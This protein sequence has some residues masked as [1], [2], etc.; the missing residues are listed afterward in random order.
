MYKT[1]FYFLTPSLGTAQD[2]DKVKTLL[3]DLEADVATLGA[4]RVQVYPS[5][6]WVELYFG[7]T[8]ATSQQM[9]GLLADFANKNQLWDSW[10]LVRAFDG[11][12]KQYYYSFITSS[13]GME[14]GGVPDDV[15]AKL[16]SG[17]GYYTTGRGRPSR[18]APIMTYH[19]GYK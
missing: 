9:R 19:L 16:D 11:L 5:S 12:S 18:G 15:T 17:E 6:G 7:N 13:S 14:A 3:A 8:S 10:L 2:E 4:P 1:N